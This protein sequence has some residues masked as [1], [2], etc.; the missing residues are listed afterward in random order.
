MKTGHNYNDFEPN[1]PYITFTALD[2][3][4]KRI[5]VKDLSLYLAHHP[6]L[7]P[8]PDLLCHSV[9]FNLFSE[10][11]IGERFEALI[12]DSFHDQ[13]N[14][15]EKYASDIFYKEVVLLSPEIVS[16]VRTKASVLE[17]SYKYATQNILKQDEIAL[18]RFFRLFPLIDYQCDDDNDDND[19]DCKCKFC[20][21]FEKFCYP[22]TQCVEEIVTDLLIQIVN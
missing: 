4:L 14:L 10:W 21:E 6:D 7:S 20:I 17:W 8:S 22:K 9:C 18:E 16:L 15:S 3:I 13:E 2:C 11:G 5:S 12:K 1:I 19:D